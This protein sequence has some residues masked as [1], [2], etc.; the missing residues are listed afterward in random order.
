MHS[1][2]NSEVGPAPEGDAPA[3]RTRSAQLATAVFAV[4]AVLAV[5]AAMVRGR[6]HWF[7]LDDYDFLATRRLG[8]FSDLMTSHNGHWSTLPI[9]EYRV[10]YHFFGLNHY[11]PYQLVLVLA[12]VSTATLLYLVMRR[13][14]VHPWIAT[15]AAVLFLFLGSGADDIEW[16]FQIGFTAALAFGLAFLLLVDHDGPIGWRDGA[17]VLCGLAALLCSGVGVAVVAGVAAALVLRRGPRVAAT[18]VGPLAAVFLVWYFTYGRR[19]PAP[20]LPKA[21]EV[22]VFVWT[23]LSSV[24]GQLVQVRFLGWLLFAV[25]VAG[26]V[27]ALRTRSLAE[28]RSDDAAPAGLL[29]GA[30]VFVATTTVSRGFLIGALSSDAA[31]VPRYLYVFAALM[32]PAIAVAASVLA[33][34]PIVVVAMCAL[35]LLGLPGNFQALEPHKAVLFAL[36]QPRMVVALAKSPLLARAPSAQQPF[37]LQM[38]GA[39]ASWVRN[40]RSAGKLPMGLAV[41]PVD[42]DT[43]RLALSLD[44]VATRRQHHCRPVGPLEAVSLEVGDEIVLP[45][46]Q[47]SVTLLGP[48]GHGLASNSYLVGDPVLRVVRGPLQVQVS[49]PKHQARASLCT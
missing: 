17:G 38:P 40:A 49:S 18:L 34:R 24:F 31:R 35:L 22:Q 10:L 8:S 46:G 29:F 11:W 6:R 36:G 3:H 19:G 39:T 44:Q 16:S 7:F 26:I 23:S 1:P 13:A 2:D 30:L 33:R 14:K 47:W 28:L 9:I 42:L 48:D 45:E 32:L 21:H 25:L 15:S 20:P 12:H 27:V 4:A 43:A 41:E 37:P 5:P